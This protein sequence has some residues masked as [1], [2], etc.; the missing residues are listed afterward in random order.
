[1][2]SHQAVCWTTPFTIAIIALNHWHYVLSSGGRC[3]RGCG[4]C[5]WLLGGGCHSVAGCSSTEKTFERESRPLRFS[6]TCCNSPIAE[7]VKYFV[8]LHTSL[9]RCHWVSWSHTY[10]SPATLLPALRICCS[11][12]IA[13][14]IKYLYSCTLLSAG[15]TGQSWKGDSAV[16]LQ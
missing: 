3:S 2:W 8:L 15:V 12:P 6:I 11:S 14:L 5:A 9:S 1:M 16:E 10:Y 13:E 4:W 7:L